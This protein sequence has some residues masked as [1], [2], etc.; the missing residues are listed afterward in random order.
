MN[1]K[2]KRGKQIK[3]EDI[4]NMNLRIKNVSK[5]KTMRYLDKVEENA[6]K[7]RYEDSIIK[8]KE[9]LKHLKFEKLA[10]R[11]YDNQSEAWE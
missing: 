10:N 9:W 8:T 4:N 11:S 5:W 6:N 1:N 7:R 3:N 2:E